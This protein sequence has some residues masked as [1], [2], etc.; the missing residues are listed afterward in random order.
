MSAKPTG[1][2]ELKSDGRY[3]QFDRLF[4]APIEDVWYSLTNP[5]ALRSWIGTY[6][7][8]PATGAVRFQMT[9]EGADAPWQ[10]V[11]ILE[12]DPPHRF[13]LDVANEP[14]A[15]RLHCHLREAGGMT[16]LTFAQRLDE[17][18]PVA[19]IGP[20][21]DYY[22]DRLHAARNGLALPAWE[23]YYPAFAEHYRS[24]HVPDAARP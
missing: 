17:S 14:H 18:T 11:S 21:W 15:W 16:T 2:Y 20:G 6:T 3:L 24:L 9:A 12:C 23:S 19:E 8:I 7:G 10:N 1:H 5:T 13:H 22:L 4:H